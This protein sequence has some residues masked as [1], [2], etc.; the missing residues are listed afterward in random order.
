M[1]TIPVKDALLAFENS[2][3]LKELDVGIAEV[4]DGVEGLYV[5]LV[6]G[7]RGDA[8]DGGVEEERRVDVG[9]KG[10]GEFEDFFYLLACL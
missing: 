4:F 3:E 9:V 7:G 1:D 2:E 6:Y 8:E 10:C 5:G